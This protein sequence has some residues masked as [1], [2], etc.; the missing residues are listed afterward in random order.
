MVG[1][2]PP[3]GFQCTA[4]MMGSAAKLA[5][6]KAACSHTCVLAF[7]VSNQAMRVQISRQ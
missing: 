1:S 2:P 3:A 6:S 5:A 7:E 4:G